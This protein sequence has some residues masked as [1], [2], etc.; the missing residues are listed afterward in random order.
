MPTEQN[1]SRGHKKR[2]RTH[3]QLIVAG[4]QVLA[5]K[6]ESLTVSDVVG[7]AQVSNGTF[8][9]YFTDRNELINAL[10]EHSLISL[11]TLSSIETLDQ[12]PARRF[13]VATGRVLKRAVENPTWGQ[14]ILRLTDHQWSFRPEIHRCVLTASYYYHF[15]ALPVQAAVG[16]PCCARPLCVAAQGHYAL[17]LRSV[18]G[19]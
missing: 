17:P 14:A 3:D 9:N 1:L 5:D 18:F 11:A 6:G 12:D 8:Y 7:Q 13:A 10:A 2:E 16:L 4:L 19:D 15:T